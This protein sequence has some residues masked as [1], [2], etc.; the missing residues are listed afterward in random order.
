MQ[1]LLS[2]I[3]GNLEALEAVLADAEAHRVNK[4]LYL[5]DTV[6]YGPNPLECLKLS[7]SWPVALQG[8]HDY[9]AI[10]TN[11][12]LS[13]FAISA[14]KSLLW[15]R[16]FFDTPVDGARCKEF[17]TERPRSYVE[18]ETLF[19]HGSPRN[20]LHEY[21]FPEDIDNQRKMERIA[22]NLAR[23]CFNGHTHVPGIFRESKPQAWEFI[24]PEDGGPGFRP[25]G[26]KTLCNV[27]SVGQPR[28]GDWR[29]CYVL[30]DGSVIRFRRVEYDVEKTVQKIYAN[31]ELDNF[32]GDRL[33]EGR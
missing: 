11:D 17:L 7:M 12:D 20:P 16:S 25:D 10:L 18:A 3:H 9:A 30:W 28:D 33:R 5:G 2:D 32:L 13:G 4:I 23:L 27:G 24:N 29:A 19:V 14:A 15:A 6:G 31:P 1:A 22:E 26:R 21:L 8:N